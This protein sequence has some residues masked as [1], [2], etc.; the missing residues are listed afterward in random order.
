MEYL[1]INYIKINPQSL[2]GVDEFNQ[3]F[4]DKIDQI[5]IDIA[6]GIEF[7]EIIQSIDIRPVNISD[8]RFSP[9]ANEIEKIFQLRT[10]KLIY[11]KVVMIIFFMK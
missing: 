10:T 6:S 3:S 1:D 2:L 5:E 7:N 11:L 4:F 9:E 8:F